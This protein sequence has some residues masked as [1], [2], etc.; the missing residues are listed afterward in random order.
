MF[1]KQMYR[2]SVYVYM[3]VCYK[4]SLVQPDY[5]EG[6]EEEEEEEEHCSPGNLHTDSPAVHCGSCTTA[7]N[8]IMS[9]I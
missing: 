8:I 1:N 9:I 2:Y 4:V 5:E 3:C 7:M 6:E